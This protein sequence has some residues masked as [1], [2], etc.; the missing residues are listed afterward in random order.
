MDVLRPPGPCA[1][2]APILFVMLPGVGSLPHEFVDEGFV[3]ALRS[4]Q[5]AADVVLV[6]SHLGYFNERSIFTRLHD[7][8]IGP[9]RAQGYRHIW[10]LGISLG[11]FGAIGYALR[12]GADIDGVVALA[13]YLGPRRLMLEISQAG[14]PRA[15]RRTQPPRGRD[16]V[17]REI[18]DWLAGPQT[19]TPPVYLGYG[20]D[21][22]FADAQRVAASLLPPARVATVPGGH[23][24]PAWRP[25]WQQWLT[26]AL[27]A[28]LLPTQCSAAA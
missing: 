18:W 8:V 26:Q 20:R 22:R 6:D 12:H 28:G 21:D 23:D 17:D 25:L 13:P 1:G 14:G 4:R 11:G 7:D 27:A 15:W 9:A 24:W 5:V 19:G 10:L 3:A 2:R 16:E